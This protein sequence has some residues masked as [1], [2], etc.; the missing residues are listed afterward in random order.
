MLHLLCPWLRRATR[1]TLSRSD[2]SLRATRQASQRPQ[3][4]PGGLNQ[5]H[6]PV[7]VANRAVARSLRPL[8][9]PPCGLAAGRVAASQRGLAASTSSRENRPRLG[10]PEHCSARSAQGGGPRVHQPHGG[11]VVAR[12]Y[13][14]R[15][16]RSSV[17][18]SCQ[19]VSASIRVRN[20]S[21]CAVTSGPGCAMTTN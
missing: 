12:P 1:T 13:G 17:W 20:G 21:I 18:P 5:P 3:R 16:V 10:R 11:G 9:M 14:R 8:S 19:R 4:N 7:S 6:L 2:R 15:A